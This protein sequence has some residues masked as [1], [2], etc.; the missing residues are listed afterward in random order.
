MCK[1]N[2]ESVKW[3]E[4]YHRCRLTHFSSFIMEPLQNIG[5]SVYS[6]SKIPNYY[7]TVIIVLN[8]I[9]IDWTRKKSCI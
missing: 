1:V 6:V 9:E 7:L 4:K 5:W 3:I 8:Y 2:P